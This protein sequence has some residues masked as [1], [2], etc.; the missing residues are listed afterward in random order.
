MNYGTSAAVKET[1]RS[2]NPFTKDKYY[3]KRRSH[4]QALPPGCED[5]SE[6]TK[7]RTTRTDS[8]SDSCP[9]IKL[10]LE[11]PD[12]ELTKL[13]Q[14][15]LLSACMRIGRVQAKIASGKDVVVVIGNTGAGKS[16][17]VNYLA[18]CKIVLK[19]AKDVGQAGVLTGKVMVVKGT[20]DKG[21][22][23]EIM[24]IGHS[25]KS[26]TFVPEIA[27]VDDHTFIDAPGFLD[28]RGAEI[29]IA[30]AVNIRA[31]LAEA[32][33]VRVLVLINFKSL[34][35][36]RGRGLTEMLEICSGLFGS[37]KQLEA[38]K[39]SLL[40][41]VSK[42]PVNGEQDLADIKEFMLEDTLPIM[43]TLVKRMFIFDAADRGSVDDG[44]WT[45]QECL[46]HIDRSVPIARPGSIFKTVLTDS[47]EKALREITEVMCENTQASLQRKE[48]MYAAGC[49]RSLEQLKAIGHVTV[50]RLLMENE[51]ELQRHFDKLGGRC[52]DLC[53]RE[54][55]AE[56]LVA[57]NELDVGLAEFKKQ[58]ASMADGRSSPVDI[59]ELRGYCADLQRK[60]DERMQ[61][62]ARNAELLKQAEGQVEL[63]AK[64]LADQKQQYAEDKH[65]RE[66][67][68]KKDQ[69]DNEKSRELFRKQLDALAAT[70]ESELEERM[71][72]KVAELEKQQKGW[73]SRNKPNAKKEKKQAEEQLAALQ[74]EQ[75][76]QAQKTRDQKARYEREQ[77]ELT[78]T[79]EAEHEQRM[80]ALQA[81]MDD[82][83]EREKAVA[84]KE[85]IVQ[86][87]KEAASGSSAPIRLAGSSAGGGSV[88]ARQLSIQLLE[89]TGT[90]TVLI[91]CPPPW[92]AVA[93][94]AHVA[95][96]RGLWKRRVKLFRTEDEPLPDDTPVVDGESLFMLVSND[97][98]KICVLTTDFEEHAEDVVQQLSQVGGGQIE[99][100]LTNLARPTGTAGTQCVD[101]QHL[102]EFD[103]VVFY[104]ACWTHDCIDTSYDRHKQGDALADFVDGGGAVLS[105][106]CNGHLH[107]RWESE[108]YCP[109]TYDGG[110]GMFTG[111]AA[112]TDIANRKAYD[113]IAQPPLFEKVP[114]IS[115]P[116][117]TSKGTAIAAST[118]VAK[119]PDEQPLFVK[120]EKQS[121]VGF[122]NVYPPS[123][124]A[125]DKY[126]VQARMWDPDEWSAAALIH[127]SIRELV[128]ADMQ[129]NFPVPS[130][131]KSVWLFGKIAC[132]IRRAI[133]K[134]GKCP[135]V[136]RP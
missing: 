21:P 38:C 28:N 97:P 83:A 3:E 45:Q 19:K 87:V 62:E 118:T 76:E 112:F 31:A 96:E 136:S 58:C 34:D 78:E 17:L 108:E 18:G 9:L 73:F 113:G 55:F 53:G 109:F 59:S 126:R 120:H 122:L 5:V 36:D 110:I 6:D 27:T 116:M 26:Q 32:R 67:Q 14:I 1:H 129:A 94:K 95:S 7:S 77:Q 60:A 16:T 37:D 50:D 107:G 100:S 125:G 72:A 23:D 44:F 24:K 33:S 105:C 85:V 30:N 119:W 66:E 64:Q 54:Q 127:N 20:A 104:A 41:G 93:I 13:E 79:R 25:K 92:T 89:M 71:D 135:R 42:C 111:P 81:K 52:R 114:V 130:V 56:A 11:N 35:A 29:N 57:I 63:L 65:E 51:M 115:G 39:D 82:V 131:D 134:G 106:Y 103:A 74:Q 49:L 84:V 40:V 69:A 70:R 132:E 123:Q 124:E 4:S 47:D 8:L 101:S 88:A 48:Y 46:H 15:E 10:K 12:R 133:R 80:A 61:R 128:D 68:Y 102:S 98:L 91:N 22:R 86:P 121:R 2:A 117:W 43:E 99:V 90:S 75:Q